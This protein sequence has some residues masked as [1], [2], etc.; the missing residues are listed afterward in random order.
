MAKPTLSDGITTVTLL[1]DS[2]ILEFEEPNIVEH[3]IPSRNGVILQDM[4]RGSLEIQLSGY[5]TSQSEKQQLQTWAK[6]RTALVYN[7]DEQTNIDVRIILPS[8]PRP[9]YPG[10]YNYNFTIKEDE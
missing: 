7:D 3:I 8:F 4:G 10:V 9:V 6:N 2:N 1:I 5:T